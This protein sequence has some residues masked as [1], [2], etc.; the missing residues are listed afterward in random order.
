MT[1]VGLFLKSYYSPVTH[2]RRKYALI[3]TQKQLKSVTAFKKRQ[4]SC[5][6]SLEIIKQFYLVGQ[7]EAKL[8]KT[9]DFTRFFD[10]FTELNIASYTFTEFNSALEYRMASNLN[11]ITFTTCNWID[12]YG[13]LSQTL[14]GMYNGHIYHP[15]FIILYIRCKECYPV[16]IVRLAKL[17][18]LVSRMVVGSNTN[19]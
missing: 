5:V 1:G 6:T 11:L 3:P 10:D 8:I 14:S 13:I 4:C 19:V 2:F 7:R 15:R 18:L 9:H 17:V 12:T 16:F